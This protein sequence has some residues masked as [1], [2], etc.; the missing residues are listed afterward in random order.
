MRSLREPRGLRDMALLV[1][2]L[3]DLDGNHYISRS[4]FQELCNRNVTLII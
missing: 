2:A 4:E 1:F 3:F